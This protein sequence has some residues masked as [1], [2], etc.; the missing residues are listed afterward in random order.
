MIQFN[1]LKLK[2]YVCSF[3]LIISSITFANSLLKINSHEQ[4]LTLDLDDNQ[5]K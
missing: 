5:I 4:I 1:I 2:L 3:Y